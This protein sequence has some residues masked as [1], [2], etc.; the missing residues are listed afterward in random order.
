MAPPSR[1]N[2]ETIDKETPIQNTSANT[3]KFVVTKRKMISSYYIGNIDISVDKQDAYDYL[4]GNGVTPTKL[5]M[6]Y[7]RHG[8]A[9]KINIFYVDKSKVESEKF[10]PDEITYRK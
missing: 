3:G 6:F 5:D 10:W 1:E 9:A 2:E 4:P 7:G 8:S